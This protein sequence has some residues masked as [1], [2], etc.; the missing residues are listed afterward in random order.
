MMKLESEP[1]GDAL[2]VRVREQRIDAA[3]AIRFKDQMREILMQPS[4]RVVLDLSEV[5]FLDSSGLG[6]VVAV[7]KLTAPGRALELAA[8]T[9]TVEK[10]FRLTRM[11]QVFTIHAAPPGAAAGPLHHA[12]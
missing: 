7:M 8:L 11:D 3:V 9:P 4:R 12:G 10:V 5:G 6:A 1:V 2:V